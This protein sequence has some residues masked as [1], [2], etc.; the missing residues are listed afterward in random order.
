MAKRWRLI[1]IDFHRR[2]RTGYTRLDMTGDSL[3]SHHGFYSLEWARGVFLSYYRDARRAHFAPST[4][5]SRQGEN[6]RDEKDKTSQA[7][8]L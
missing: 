7:S 5:P 3:L 4:S 1:G 6:H 8:L 2:W